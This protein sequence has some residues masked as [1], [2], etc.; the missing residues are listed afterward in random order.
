LGGGA[1]WCE[2][3]EKCASALTIRLIAGHHRH[4]WLDRAKP[5]TRHGD[6]ARHGPW[7]PGPGPRLSALT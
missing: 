7:L 1:G 6:R 5:E 4:P 2:L 3:I